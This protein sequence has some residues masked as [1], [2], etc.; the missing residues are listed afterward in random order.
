[1]KSFE[2]TL[3]LLSSALTA[4]PQAGDSSLRFIREGSPL[5]AIT[6][7]LLIDGTGAAPKADQTIL[8]RNGKIDSVGA[9][10]TFP[11]PPDA[12]VLEGTG[13]TL[14]PG[15]V[16]MHEHCSIQARLRNPDC[17]LSSSR[18]PFLFSIWRAG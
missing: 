3:L 18:L 15:L 2:L 5:I 12:R 1:M 11:I 10:T 16:G 13:H 6:H 4:L 8:L 17:F 9:S 14:I 7:T